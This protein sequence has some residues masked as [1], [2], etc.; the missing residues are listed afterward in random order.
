MALPSS[1]SGPARVYLSPV[2]D[3]FDGLVVSW[4]IGARPD[5]ELVNTM[6]DSAIES[7]AACEERPVVHSDLGA[8]YRWPGWLSRIKDAGLV[9]SMSRK[10][11]SPDNAACEGF[12]GRLKTELFYPRDWRATTSNNSSKLL[13]HKFSG[14]PQNG[15]KSR[16]A[17][18]APSNTGIVLESRYNSV[19]GNCRTPATYGGRFL[20]RGPPSC[21]WGSNPIPQSNW[22]PWRRSAGRIYGK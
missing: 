9:R 10:G 8:H 16:S 6:L 1:S 22:L 7:V 11:H 21:C 17:S 5:T 14:R 3:C 18:S 4:S 20:G 2:I 13:T 19:Q 15:S 12:F